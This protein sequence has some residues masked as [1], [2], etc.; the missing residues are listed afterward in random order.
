MEQTLKILQHIGIDKLLTAVVVLA[1]CLIATRYIMRFFTKL[2]AKLTHIDPALHSMLRTILR[3]L[4]VFISLMISAN[5][6]GIPITSFV[7]LF[8]VAG[9]AVSLAVQGVLTNLAG[10]VIIL[11]SKPFTLGDYIEADSVSGTVEEIN[12]LHTRMVTPDGKRIFVPNNLLYTSKLIN[13]TSSGMR[14]IDLLVN[15]SYDNTPEQVRAAVMQAM[16]DTLG[17][18]SEPAPE[19]LLENYGDS[20]ISYTIRAWTSASQYMSTRYALNEAIYHAFGQSGVKMTYPHMEIH[21]Q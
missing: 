4:L 16:R 15:A 7:A 6:I 5:T 13:Y 1:L 20:A 10:G 19:V 12:F 11:A 3:F 21:L 8:S 9:L 18:A 14:R 2:L 17:I